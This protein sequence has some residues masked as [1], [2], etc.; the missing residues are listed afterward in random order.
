MNE[1]EQ[2]DSRPRN[3]QQGQGPQRPPGPPQPP[4]RQGQQGPQGPH[5]QPPPPQNGPRHAQ[6]PTPHRGMPQQQRPPQTPGQGMAQ[7]RP[8]PPGQGGIRP[9]LGGQYAHTP[10]G[11]QPRQQPPPPQHQQRPGPGPHQQPGPP[12][13]RPAG[14]GPGPA[15]HQPQQQPQQPG[16]VPGAVAMPPP[17]QMGQVLGGPIAYPGAAGV[18]E[19]GAVA[20]A[21][22][23]G[24]LLA[25]PLAAGSSPPL[26]PP[27]PPSPTPERSGSTEQEA[28]QTRKHGG[29]APLRIGHHHAPAEAL[30]LLQFTGS[31]FG[32][33]LGR[34]QAGQPV[35][36]TLFRPEATEALLVGGMWA[37]RLLAFRALRFGARVVMF[38][39]QANGW[40]D[41]G[42]LAV[43]RSD[44]LMVLPPGSENEL[45][46]SADKPLLCVYD[47]QP[48]P[49]EAPVPWRT[50]LTVLRQL[51]PERAQLAKRADLVLLQRL[52]PFEASLVASEMSFTPDTTQEISRL[53]DDMVAMFMDTTRQYAALTVTGE[54]QRLGRP[55]RY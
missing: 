21:A 51:T 7:Q 48:P 28:W 10:P 16:P 32:L 49:E 43:G 15:P 36:I 9:V 8:F 22:A 17:G 18:G 55:G 37:A 54:E 41:L 31:S 44:R 13:Q 35:A 11:G 25:Q 33:R 12:Q 4:G 52:A 40:H 50:R 5:Q 29:L 14:P 20:T 42:T 24:T 27:T 46:A 53:R 47:D 45:T 26:A 19:A 39:H 30:D 3:S 34:D 23:T 38:T 6:P 1:P 2:P